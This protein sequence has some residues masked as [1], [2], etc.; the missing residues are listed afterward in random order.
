MEH[1]GRYVSITTNADGLRGRREL[2]PSKQ[3][4]LVLGDSYTFGVYVDDDE[5][6]PAILN[7]LK[8]FASIRSR[9]PA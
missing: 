4:V 1:P 8:G 6:Y 5:T 7:Q 3:K 9:G 2:D